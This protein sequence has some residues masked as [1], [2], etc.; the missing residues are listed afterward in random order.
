M[1]KGGR[2]VSMVLIFPMFSAAV[3]GPQK[4]LS[5]VLVAV[6]IS[7]FFFFSADNF[8]SP[9]TGISES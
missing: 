7:E 9:F 1:I 4:E 3:Y 2:Q 6:K 5:A 8:L